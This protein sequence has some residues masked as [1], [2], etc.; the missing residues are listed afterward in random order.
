MTQPGIHGQRLVAVFLFGCL[1][2]NYPLLFLFNG[3]Q[4]IFGVPL[5]YVYIFAAWALLIVLIALVIARSSD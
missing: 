5:L 4:R 1:L 2:F 3:A